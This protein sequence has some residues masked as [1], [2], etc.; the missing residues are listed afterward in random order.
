[1]KIKEQYS[2]FA[3]KLKL[4]SFDELDVEFEIG[5]ID[6]KNKF[7]FKDIARAITN[8]IGYFA[9]LLEPAVNPPVPTIHSMVETNNIERDDKTKIMAL[10]KKLMHLGHLG[11]SLEVSSGDEAFA[12]YINKIWKQWPEIKKSMEFCMKSI[13]ESWT[14]EKKE[15]NIGLSYTG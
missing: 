9:S 2:K 4:P 10:Y 1:M 12:E 7:Y 14:T 5:K 13:V 15:E 11:Y 6:I 3:K 8:K